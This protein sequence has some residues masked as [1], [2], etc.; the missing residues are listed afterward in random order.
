MTKSQPAEIR[1]ARPSSTLTLASL[2]SLL[3][4]S[5]SVLVEYWTGENRSYAWSI[6]NGGIRSFPL[7]PAAVLD[8]RCAAFRKALLATAER[9]PAHFDRRKSQDAIRGCNPGGSSWAQAWPGRCF[10]PGVLP[11]ATSTVLVVGDGAIETLPFVAL[12]GLSVVPAANGQV[13]R[14]TFLNEPSATVFA[15]LEE[16][17]M[18]SRA[19]RLA[20]FTCRSIERQFFDQATEE[21]PEP[22]PW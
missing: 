13:R 14:I 2:Q 20:V 15:F 6:T 4:D 16:R 12:P 19:I 18:T 21:G 5:R 7:P 22:L 10:P 11:P 3:P 8:R 1:K 17:S 9:D